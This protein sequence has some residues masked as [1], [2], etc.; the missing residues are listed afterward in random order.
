VICRLG[1]HQWAWFGPIY[2][3]QFMNR[4]CKRCR[5]HQVYSLAQGDYRSDWHR[6]GAEDWLTYNPA[7]PVLS[8]ETMDV[9]GRLRE[10]P[11]D[12]VAGGAVT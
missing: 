5:E 11:V 8:K 6:V 3:G 7:P 10:A 12:T 2:G 1:I 9:I 4:V